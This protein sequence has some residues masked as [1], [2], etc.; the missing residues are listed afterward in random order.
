LSS[1]DLQA[2]VAEEQV[3]VAIEK[4]REDMPENFILTYIGMDGNVQVMA[5]C[6]LESAQTMLPATINSIAERYA[7]TKAAE[8]KA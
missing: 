7:Y 1:D 4:L 5:H 8:V 2:R 6:S 3:A